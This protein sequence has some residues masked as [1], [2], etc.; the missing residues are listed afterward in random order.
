MPNF[1]IATI[2]T[3]ADF[4]RSKPGDIRIVHKAT[5]YDSTLDANS[6]F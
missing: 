3:E 2:Y 6:I 5:V 4:S 1:E